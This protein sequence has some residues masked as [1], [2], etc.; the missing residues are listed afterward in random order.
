MENRK[1]VTLNLD[2]KIYDEF[3]KTVETINGKKI[4]YLDLALKNITKEI[5]NNDMF[6]D[7]FKE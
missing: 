6:K 7:M 1:N 2:S 5:K 3:L 4:G